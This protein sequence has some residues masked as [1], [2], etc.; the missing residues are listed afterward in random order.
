MKRILLFIIFF[1]NCSLAFVLRRGSLFATPSWSTLRPR[2]T[3]FLASEPKNPS[4]ATQLADTNQSESR[5]FRPIAQVEQFAR[6]PV[7]PA[8]NGVVL[9]LVSQVFGGALAARLEQSITGRVCPNFLDPQQT[10]PFV[11]LVHHCHSFGRLDPLRYFQS[12]FFPEG[13]PAHFHVGFT[14]ITYILHGG[15]VHRDSEGVKQVY[16]A[17]K[18]RHGGKDVQWLFTGSGLQHEEMFDID[19]AND[20]PLNSKQEL[21]QIWLNVPAKYKMSPPQTLLLG[22]DSETPVVVVNDQ[23]NRS[24]STTRVIAGS[25]NGQSSAA[26]LMSPALVFHVTVTANGVWEYTFPNASYETAFLY[27]RQGSLSVTATAESSCTLVPVHHTAYFAQSGGDSVRITSTEGT[28][29]LLLAGAP[30]QEPVI[31]SGSVVMNSQYEIQ[32]ANNDYARGRFGQPWSHKISDDEWERHLEQF[33]PR[34]F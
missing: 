10:S 21:Y 17:E 31:A 11:L 30:L 1:H 6:L 19:Y 8:W 13:F 27:V 5:N 18:E 16:G 3:T 2:R 32:Q 25:Y 14:T 28:D 29:F 4:I 7:W 23:Q 24:S 34:V 12:T 22:G 33:G 20:S 9:W 15:F 26:P